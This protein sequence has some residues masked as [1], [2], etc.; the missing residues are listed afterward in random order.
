L[1]NMG[2]FKGQ[3]GGELPLNILK[4]GEVQVLVVWTATALEIA[5]KAKAAWTA[6]GV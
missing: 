3:G 1:E 2:N 6:A 4:G 5:E